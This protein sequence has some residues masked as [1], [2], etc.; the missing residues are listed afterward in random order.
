LDTE[1][2]ILNNIEINLLNR[3]RI[4][5]KETEW[6]NLVFSTKCQPWT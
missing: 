6:I 5:D 2:F 3:E 4:Q 1:F